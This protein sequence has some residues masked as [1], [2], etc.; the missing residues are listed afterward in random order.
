MWTETRLGWDALIL[1]LTKILKNATQ[2]VIF[3][4]NTQIRQ[5][6]Y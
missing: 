2:L 4:I 1:K 3:T 6:V 5:H